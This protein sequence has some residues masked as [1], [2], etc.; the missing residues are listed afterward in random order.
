MCNPTSILSIGSLFLLFA[1]T[2]GLVAQGATQ[3]QLLTLRKQKFAS[4]FLEKAPWQRD[5]DKARAI[6]KQNKQHIFA[7]FTRSYAP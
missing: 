4:A 2:P 3:G 7:Y 5:F 1:S 6:A